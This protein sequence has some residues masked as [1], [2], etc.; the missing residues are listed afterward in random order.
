MDGPRDYHNKWS[1]SD[2]DKYHMISLTCGILK[3]N[4][5]MDLLKNKNRHTDIENKF[6]ATKMDSRGEGGKLGVWD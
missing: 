3:N 1:K 5:Q 4:K 6:I 2:K